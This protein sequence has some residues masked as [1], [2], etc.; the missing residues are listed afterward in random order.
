A[1]AAH[2]PSPQSW[3]ALEAVSA[4]F[5]GKRGDNDSQHFPPAV[6]LETNFPLVA[7]EPSTGSVRHGWEHTC[8]S[9]ANWPKQTCENFPFHRWKHRREGGSLRASDTCRPAR[10]SRSDRAAPEPRGRRVRP[11]GDAALPGRDRG[12]E[13]GSGRGGLLPRE[14]CEDLPRSA[15]ALCEGRAG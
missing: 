1:L 12:G 4:R 7:A 8:F 11:R 5:C 14:P 3:L 9:A 15:R 6:N 2:S 10:R 13:R